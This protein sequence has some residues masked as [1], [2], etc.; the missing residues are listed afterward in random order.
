MMHHHTAMLSA[1]HVGQ[2]PVQMPDEHTEACGYCLFLTHVPGLP[3]A[4]A[5]LSFA[6][7]LHLCF[8]LVWPV[9]QVRHFFFWLYPHTRAPPQISASTY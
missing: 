5:G 2:K 6:Q 7:I 3:A 8:Q 1:H 9:L 4:L